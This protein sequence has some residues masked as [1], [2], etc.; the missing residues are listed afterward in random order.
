MSQSANLAEC[1]TLAEVLSLTD[2]KTFARGKAYFHEGA[3][4]RLDEK[5]DT[6]RA[7]VRGTHPYH[8]ELAAIHLE[9]CER[10]RPEPEELARRLFR[11]QLEGQWGTFADA[12]PAYAE[13]LG[14]TG[15]RVYRELYNEAWSALP[16]LTLSGKDRTPFDVQ[17]F[18][19][20]RAMAALAEFDGDID[21]LIRIESKDLSTVRRFLQIAS[22]C[23]EHGRLDEGLAWAE[24]GIEASKK[25]VDS[26]LL[27]FCVDGYVS[28]REFDK[29]DEYAWRRFVSYPGAAP[30]KDLMTAAK[31]TGSYDRTRQR[32]LD[33]MWA[34]VG[35]E[36]AGKKTRGPWA[37][38]M[39]TEL[40]QLFLDERDNEA[41][42]HAFTGGPIAA[43]ICQPMAAVRARTHPRDALVVYQRLLAGTVERGT[44]AAQYKDA[45]EIVKAIG[46][47]WD[48]LGEHAQFKA[49]LNAI[50]QTYR[51]KRKFIA[52]L[53][54]LK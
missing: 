11:F 28:R 43:Q 52:L 7:N 23:R 20:S 30:F 10:T 32:A 36:E 21:A 44:S 19:V 27:T 38:T 9:A 39:R 5:D 16:S 34:M 53:D 41:A 46:K 40:V 14:D 48:K 31:A 4:S 24:K 17:H 1:L 12:F 29:A 35:E 25:D 18:K 49:E 51:A 42:W 33:H 15:V 37:A 26:D 54:T 2:A 50:R 45:F 3:V 13:A 6:V 22:L 8:E 47:L